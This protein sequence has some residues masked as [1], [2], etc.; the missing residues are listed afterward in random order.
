MQ[1]LCFKRKGEE[2]NNFLISGH[3]SE[4]IGVTH[5]LVLEMKLLPQWIAKVRNKTD[6]PVV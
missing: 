3:N 6:A 5:Y 2:E 1:P 4:H